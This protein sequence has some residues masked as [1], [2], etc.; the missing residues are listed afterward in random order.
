MVDRSVER[1]RPLVYPENPSTVI[2]T[3][4]FSESNFPRWIDMEAKKILAG[5]FLTTALVLTPVS[6]AAATP[7]TDNDPGVTE[8]RHDNRDNHRP[9]WQGDRNHQ[10]PPWQGDRHDD[11]PW[12]SPWRADCFWLGPWL[13]CLPPW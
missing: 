7:A 12:N 1:R 2:D 13:V 8:V 9:P 3:V 10:R 4:E 11:R 6:T 5:T